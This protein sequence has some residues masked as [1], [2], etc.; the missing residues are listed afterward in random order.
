MKNVFRMRLFGFL[1][2]AAGM[3]APAMPRII[4]VAPLEDAFVLDKD[5]FISVRYEGVEDVRR[6]RVYFD[7]MNISGRLRQSGSTVVFVPDARFDSREDLI[8]PHIITVALYGRFFR[9]LEYRSYRCYITDTDSLTDERRVAMIQ[10]GADLEGVTPVDLVA[11]GR[12]YAGV[13]YLSVQDSG[14]WVGRL[15]GDLS[16]HAGPWSYSS[17]VSLYSDVLEHGQSVQTFRANTG[18]R[19]VVR[20][21][22]GDN[23]PE[24]NHFL[25]HGTRMRGLELELSTPQSGVNLDLA[26]GTTRRAV[27]PYVL[28]EE[29]LQAKIDSLLG[30]GDPISFLDSADFL[31]DGTYRRSM[32]T[33]RLHFGSGRRFKLGLAFLKSSDDP[34]S[35]KQLKM[36]L[37]TSAVLASGDTAQVVTYGGEAPGDNF[38]LAVDVE[39]RFWDRRISLFGNYALSFLT[40][41]I[42]GGPFKDD[43]LEEQLGDVSLWIG[44]EDVQTIIVLNETTIPLPAGWEGLKRST[45]WD[46]GLRLDFP[47]GRFRE[48]F[49]FRYY[50]IGPNF[51][52]HGNPSLNTNRNGFDIGEELHMFDGKIAVKSDVGFYRDLLDGVKPAV[53]NRFRMSGSV[54]LFWS[55]EYPSATVH[56][57]T[58]SGERLSEP[59]SL[60]DNEDDANVFGIHS[61]YTHDIGKSSSTFSINYNRSRFRNSAVVLAEDSSQSSDSAKRYVPTPFL[62]ELRGNSF[63]G[64][65]Y[66][67]IQDSPL[68]TRLSG[69][70]TLSEGDY[71]LSQYYISGGTTWKVVKEV[72]SATF[73]AGIRHT[74]DHD[75]PP[76][77][78]WDVLTTVTFNPG[79]RSSVYGRLGLER[80]FGT[81]YFDRELLA[82]YELRF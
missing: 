32:L 77:D 70:G 4:P 25:L 57:M 26:L 27:E 43:S 9:L 46:A 36:I 65:W 69:T 61:Q 44:P 38:A 51:V 62:I 60:S 56:F 54:S 40:R 47:I 81:D 80:E 23:W 75:G 37:D 35:I 34:E 42:S 76:S 59:A 5:F 29:A 82:A 12:A 10:A 66:N 15:E 71:A 24:S 64:S 49:E 33:G 20:V 48:L 2:I 18:Y 55:P 16:G 58:T 79:R 31:S 21:G 19:N 39:V 8:G 30:I 17:V 72:F 7:R 22:I 78:E 14:K 53:R 1:M 67:I 45:A 74:N 63:G 13:E 41:N 73:D 50:Y 3:L 11:S 6:V 68:E 52:S 28:D